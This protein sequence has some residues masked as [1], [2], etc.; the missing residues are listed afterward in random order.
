MSQELTR[1]Q[2]ARAAGAAGIT[3]DASGMPETIS[4]PSGLDRPPGGRW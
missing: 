4:V 3:A 1:A 2:V